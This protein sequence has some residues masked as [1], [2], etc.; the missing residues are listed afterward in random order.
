[1]IPNLK[2]AL[3][4]FHMTA[5]AL[6]LFLMIAPHSADAE[7]FSSHMSVQVDH[8]IEIRNGG[9]V[10][11][12]DTFRLSP[13]LGQKVEPLYGFSVGF[14]FEYGFNL[15]YV[16]AHVEPTKEKLDID[17][18]TELG[19]IGYYGVTVIFHEPMDLSDGKSYNFTVVFVFSNLVRVSAVRTVSNP[20]TGET[21]ATLEYTLNF[22]LYPSLP[23]DASCNVTVLLPDKASYLNSS[24]TEDGT[25]FNLTESDSRI[26]LNHK[27]SPVK[28]FAYEPSWLRFS[29]EE[30]AATSVIA[31]NNINRE[32]TL[33]EWGHIISRDLYNVTNKLDRGLS[34]L[35][36]YLPSGAVEPSAED[37]LGFLEMELS[38]ENTTRYAIHLEDSHRSP[39]GKDETKTFV[40]SYSLPWESCINRSS[41]RDYHLSFIPLENFSWTVRRL[42]VTL[43]LPEGAKFYAF[44]PAPHNLRRSVFKE[45]IT[46]T[47]QNVTPLHDLR[48]DFDFEYTMLWASF[49][50]TLWMGI[51]IIVASSIALL[52]K[53]SKPTPPP[54]TIPINMKDLRRFVEAYEEKQRV[55]ADIES[56]EQKARKEKIPRRQY[57]IRKRT[58]ENR[59]SVLSR[60]LYE[61]RESIRTAGPRYA[62]LMRQIEV[63][64]IELKGVEA[65][66]RRTTTLFRR[67]EISKPAHNKLL[68]EY[69]RREDRARTMIEGALLRLKE[70]IR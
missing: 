32:I 60:D 69:R 52:H 29:M 67:G 70:E 5:L 68:E 8:L 58:L 23:I 25:D 10:L 55:L 65:D 19:K 14:P 61:L 66:V 9:L 53:A 17:T 63:A 33:D 47:F 41:W 35:E 62:D 26:T 11:I 39:L 13:Q 48:L 49:R 4:A 30:K 37:E 2:K 44:S 31:V 36:I 40:V 12:S 46:Y 43:T 22:P 6:L 54:P 51:V 18:E 21:T 20:V 56:T 7:Q 16:T 50:P 3:L 42:T 15:D 24:L 28:E 34:E 38:E 59:L 27:K 57:K 1:M 64:E 45:T